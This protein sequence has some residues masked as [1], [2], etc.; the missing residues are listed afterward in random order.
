MFCLFWGYLSHTHKTLGIAKSLHT[1]QPEGVVGAVKHR[2][3][4]YL[5]KFLSSKFL[6]AGK[7]SWG[8]RHIRVPRVPG[9]PKGNSSWQSPVCEPCVELQAARLGG[10]RRGEQMQTSHSLVKL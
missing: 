7:R 9:L 3:H 5:G 6:E 1:K 2:H 4:L 8:N 10:L